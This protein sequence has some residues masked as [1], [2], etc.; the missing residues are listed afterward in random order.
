MRNTMLNGMM[1]LVV[2]DALGC[3]VQFLSR[4]EIKAHGLVT[5]MEEF[6]TYMMPKG[7]WT[8]D[9]SMALA[10]LASMKEMDD[11]DP[12]DIME[13]FMDWHLNGAYTPYGQAFDQG[14]T[15]TSAILCYRHTKDMLTCGRTG[16][17]A[18]GNGA[19]MRIL[20][21]CIYYAEMVLSADA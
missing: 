19:L 2:G 9:S 15:C 16:E 7:T 14:L 11:V 3:P 1:G 10:T 21:V 12:V 4:K 20:P 18:N 13:R 8:D 6:G 5:D 17:H